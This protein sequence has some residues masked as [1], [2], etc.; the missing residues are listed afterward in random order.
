MIAPI[1][2]IATATAT[3]LVRLAHR[4]WTWLTCNRPD[5]PAFID[6]DETFRRR[7]LAEWEYQ[8]A[9]EGQ[10]KIVRTSRGCRAMPRR[11]VSGIVERRRG[12]GL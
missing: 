8:Q 3:R 5:P 12:V 2:A 7:A 9:L 6:L 11:R 1:A 10:S 4:L